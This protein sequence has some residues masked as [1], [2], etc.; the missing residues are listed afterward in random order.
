MNTKMVRWLFA[1]LVLLAGYIA[2][3]RPAFTPAPL[4]ALDSS[5]VVSVLYPTQESKVD[6]G[7]LTRFIVQVAE[8]QG[9]AVSD[10]QVTLTLRDPNG[11]SIATL[12]AIP[13]DDGVYRTDLWAIPHHT[14]AGV[15]SV[16]AD[17]KT[18]YAQGNTTGRF[19]VKGSTS[20]VLLSKYGF[21]Q[22]APALGGS[23]PQLGA[24]RGDAQNGMIRWGVS[25]PA[26]HV[27]PE[28][29]VEIQWRAGD[30]KLASSEA[31]RQFL[32]EKLGDLGSSSV[33]EIGSF[34]PIQFKHWDAWQ[35]QARGQFEY[36]Q[37]EWVVFYAPEVGK[38]FA[39]GTTA[40]Q[41]P[42]GEDPHAALRASFEVFPDIH[43]AGVAPDPLP[44]LLPAPQLVSP[45]L[46]ARFL[47]VDQ[48]IV[49]QWKP[50]KE[51]AQD[52][53]YEVKVDYDY[54]ETNTIVALTTRQTQITLPETLYRTPNCHVFNWQVT[55]KRQTGVDADGQLRGEP[56]SYTS[57]YWYVEW[58]YPAGEKAPFIPACPNAQF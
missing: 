20:D 11:Q 16:R 45:P 43:A 7:Q 31:V 2:L 28:K 14:L 49:L 9:A 5:L 29:W 51:L 48:P 25:I 37:M 19:N 35:A 33:R 53:Y 32:L 30:Y 57:L 1:G 24:E 12:P 8:A 21:W 54:R 50:M 56:V 10:A 18:G 17:A 39:I 6:M 22:D 58:L 15:W 38:T 47:G 27:L 13:G 3:I 34:H 36:T 52:E 55:I 26:Q 4:P 42:I 44:M 41:P 46:G 23:V 40:V